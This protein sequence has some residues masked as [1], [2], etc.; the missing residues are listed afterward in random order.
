M[1]APASNAAPQRPAPAA[2]TPQTAEVADASASMAAPAVQDRS[3]R[4]DHQAQLAER[5]LPSALAKAKATRPQALPDCD[6]HMDAQALAEQA[7]RI[8]ARKA[9]QAAG[10]ALPDPAPVCQPRPPAPNAPVNTP[11]ASPDSA[12][13]DSR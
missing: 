9:A 5:T 6:P 3:A 7:R 1:P 13:V 8:Q 12:P 10:Q 11:N 4:Q 2:R